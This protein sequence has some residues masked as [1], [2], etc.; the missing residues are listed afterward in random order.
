MVQSWSIFPS[1]KDIKHQNREGI[2]DERIYFKINKV[3][4]ISTKHKGFLE[5]TIAVGT[6]LYAVAVP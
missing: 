6:C 2:V 5:F 1:S 4:L 3:Y